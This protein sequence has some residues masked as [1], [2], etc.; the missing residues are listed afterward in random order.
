[1]QHQAPLLSMAPTYLWE[2][3]TTLFLEGR[4]L[5][6]GR[7]AATIW[8]NVPVALA[9]WWHRQAANQHWV[10]LLLE[11]S[12]MVCLSEESQSC[13]VKDASSGGWCEVSLSEIDIASQCR[14][15]HA[16]VLKH[17]LDLT[18]R[19]PTAQGKCWCGVGFGIPVGAHSQHK[20]VALVSCYSAPLGTEKTIPLSLGLGPRACNFLRSSSVS[21]SELL[22]GRG[23]RL[24]KKSWCF[25][26]IFM[27]RPCQ[28]QWQICC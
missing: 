20:Q 27:D 19:F 12:L 5:G 8:T 16:S 2:L 7:S 25:F 13:Q 6:A 21:F 4:M 24:G 11:K 9:G 28:T 26:H 1:M 17:R 3:L 10:Y 22:S 23:G 18:V 15:T 14:W